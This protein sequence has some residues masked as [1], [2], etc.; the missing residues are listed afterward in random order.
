M[1][2]RFYQFNKEARGEDLS[3]RGGSN[4]AG[5]PSSGSGNDAGNEDDEIL[6]LNEVTT[7]AQ[8]FI[9]KNQNLILGVMGGLALL[10]GGYFAYNHLYKIPKQNEAITAM[11]QAEN[12]FAQDSF[13]RALENPQGT[14]FIDIID[15]FGGTATANT[16]KYYAGISYLNLGKFESAIE[17]LEDYS[18]K[19]EITPAMKLGALGDAYAE[20]KELDKALDLYKDAASKANNELVAP[21]YLNKTALLA[22]KLGK[23]DVANNAIKTLLEKYPQ[24]MEVPD[25]E[26][27]LARLEAT[28][29]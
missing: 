8:S 2:K 5:I 14:G 6:N 15:E 11:W 13:A 24:A 9:E 28:A 12:L 17:M 19:D 16:A 22:Y 25:A 18:P 7:K 1:A 27:L 10:I 23:N 21:Y 26:K 4:P 20:T 3:K 29:Q